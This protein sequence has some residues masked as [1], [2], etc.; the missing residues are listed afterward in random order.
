MKPLV[1]NIQET[2]CLVEG[3]LKLNGYKVFEHVRTSLDGGGGLAMG[4]S[5][6]VDPKLTR[7]GGDEAEAITVSLNLKKIKI[8]CTT[9]YGPQNDDTNEK[10]DNFWQYLDEEAKKADI[11]GEGFLLQGDLNAW[12]GSDIIPNDPRTQNNNG[13]RFHN[14]LKSNNLSV[15]NALKLCKGLITRIRSREGKIQKSVID[16]FVVCQRLVPHV[17]EM[18]IDD[19][20]GNILTNYFGPKKGK[21]AVDTDHMTM[22]LKMNLKTSSQKSQ[23]IEIF[24]FKNKKGQQ[25]FKQCTT[26][27][28][29]FTDCFKDL[30]PL[31]DQCYKWLATLEAHCVKAY[32]IIRIRNK[33]MK[34]SAAEKMIE[35]RNKLKKLVDDGDSFKEG[36]LNDIEKKIS[37][38]IAEE[39]KSK[40]SQFQK[41]CN[42]FGSINVTEMWKL[43]KHIWPKKKET[44]PTAKKNNQGK[45]VTN[46][47]ELKELY[48][49]E[50]KERLRKRPTHPDFEAI[51]KLKDEVFKLK[52]LKA[53]EKKTTDWTTSDLNLVLKE[54]KL[55]KARDPEGMSRE[56]FHPSRIGENLKESLLIMFNKLKKNGLVPTFMR[57]AIIAPIPKKGSQFQLKNERGIF[58]VNS[59]RAM[60]MKLI[61]NSKYDTLERN[62][63]E[64]NIGSRKNKSCIDHIFVLN[65]IVHEQLKSVKNKPIRLQICDFQQMFDG[66]DL[67]ESVS[68]LYDSGLDDDHLILVYE[69][70]RNIKM[71]VK[72]P[73]GFTVEQSLDENIL[74]GDTL[75]SIIASNQVDSIG[76]ELLIEQPDFLF[77]YKNEVPVGVMGMVDDT[78][79]VS[80]EGQKSQ[81]MNAFFN[82]KA[83][84]K[85]LQFSELK[86]HTMT[87]H[88]SKRKHKLSDLKVD[89]WKQTY[90]DNDVLHEIFNEDHTLKEETEQ[91][92]LGC[93]LSNDG[94]NTK[95]IKMRTNKS[96]GTRKIIRALIKGLG[97][98]TVESGI[99]YF[100]SLLRGSLLYATETMINLKES[101]SKM[102]EKTEESTLRD[103][104]KTKFSAPRH[105]LYLEL[106]IIPAR[107][108]IKQRK[109]MYL[110]TI[111]DNTEH[112]LLKKTY[113]AQLKSPTRGDWVSEVKDIIKEF[114]IQI[115]FEE[116]SIMSRKKFKAIVKT[117]IESSAYCYLRAIQQQKEKGKLIKYNKLIMQPY[118]RSKENFTLKEQQEMFAFRSQMNDIKANFCSRN[119]IEHCNKCLNEMNNNHLFQCTW[120]LQNEKDL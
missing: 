39:E 87:I 17:K 46:P 4:C 12:L 101:D 48:A 79:C 74:Q 78:I 63:S 45:L 25:T 91:K 56:I 34:T 92:Y 43:K 71:K 111:L 119:K 27:T 65:S 6:K 83:A 9:A 70:N 67:Q 64:S 37:E 73:N 44:L 114:D 51:Q 33:N 98:Y 58:L 88:K 80:E 96:I 24:D 97:K 16:F 66:M 93:I 113:K 36:K 15:V 115:S 28:N 59:V 95:S 10:K 18:V 116:I 13:K 84:E 90:D 19:K 117:K 2:K 61:Y 29:E 108:V 31:S 118:L 35:E 55:G 14:F 102:I 81:Q 21:K 77:R 86:C 62:M 7:T 20:K 22:M 53:K 69:A 120:K 106:G 85:K 100:K 47:N 107:F 26:Q 72:T 40:A 32:P 30:S 54:I 94:T 68:D 109:L 42:D 76:K 1:W 110:K 89:I 23:R 11:E 57:K 105:I 5:V 60:L 103:L 38:V 52:L 104:V 82:V 75:S 41:Y 49:K 3:S 112:S 99:I 8:S 50:F